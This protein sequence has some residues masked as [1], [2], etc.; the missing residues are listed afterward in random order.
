MGNLCHAC[1]ARLGKTGTFESKT[2]SIIHA[3]DLNPFQKKILAKRYVKQVRSYEKRTKN[4]GFAYNIFRTIVTVGSI[5]LP[6]LLSIQ[7]N[8]DYSYKIYWTTW[9]ISIVITICNGC[10]QLY[11]LDKNYIVTS[12]IVQK[13]KSEG[14]QY[15]ECA[16]KYKN[17]THQDNFVRFCEI[18]ERLK[19]KQVSKEIKFLSSQGSSNTGKDS[20]SIITLSDHK[21]HKSAH[22]PPKLSHISDVANLKIVVDK[23]KK[24]SI[25]QHE[26]L[27]QSS[28]EFLLSSENNSKHSEV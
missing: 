2:R 23:I 1:I 5:I 3:L 17:H 22:S 24:R 7:N 19:M 11:N 10:I 27:H 13:L 25:S 6:A 20:D 14:W 9:G 16:G 15:F 21:S 4:L 12:L 26:P 8:D 18:I 28:D